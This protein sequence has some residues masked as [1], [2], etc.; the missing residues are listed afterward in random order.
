MQLTWLLALLLSRGI[1]ALTWPGAAR[2]PIDDGGITGPAFF[3]QVPRRRSGRSHL[4]RR[5]R[6]A[7]VRRP[8]P[9]GLELAGLELAGSGSGLRVCLP[10][11]GQGPRELSA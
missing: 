11:T 1:L 5:R 3:D 9:A 4:R 2:V 10:E 7:A 8:V 6:V